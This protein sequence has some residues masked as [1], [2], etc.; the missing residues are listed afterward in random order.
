MDT[1]QGPSLM[2]LRTDRRAVR[3]DRHWPRRHYRAPHLPLLLVYCRFH[4]LKSLQIQGYCPPFLPCPAAT[5]PLSV[6]HSLR[7]VL[8]SLNLVCAPPLP[9]EMTENQT[10]IQT[11]TV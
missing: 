4:D 11:S 3:T 8:P 10:F 6:L 9:P 2:D 5:L 7:T 1:V